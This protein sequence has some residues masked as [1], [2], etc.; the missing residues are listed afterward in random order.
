ML[1]FVGLDP[2]TGIPRYS[3]DL[4]FL[5]DGVDVITAI[6]A[7]FA[8]PEMIS[9]GVSRQQFAA[10]VKEKATIKFGQVWQGLYDCIRNWWLVLRLS[11]ISTIIGMI[12]GLG[13][14]TASWLS[15]GH[16]VQSSKN[17]EEFGKGRVEGVIGA[18][19]ST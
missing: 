6:L 1:S 10:D 18:E 9:L 14:E 19:T 11:I 15:Y 3:G 13:G 4:L 16:T 12:P 17:P 8:I 2:T 7:F 5:W